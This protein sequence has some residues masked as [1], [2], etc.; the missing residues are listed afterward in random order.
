LS[1]PVEEDGFDV[2]FEDSNPGK[3]HHDD[4]IETSQR[5]EKADLHSD[6]DSGANSDDDDDDDDDG[7]DDDD[8]DEGEDSEDGINELID[9]RAHILHIQMSLYP[10]TLH[11]FLSS[12]DPT[13]ASEPSNNFTH[14]YHLVPTMQIMASILAGLQHVHSAG[15]VHRDIKPQNIFFSFP[16][17]VAESCCD[18][19]KWLNPRIG[20][21]GLVAKLARDGMQLEDWDASQE[22]IPTFHQ[23]GDTTG[24]EQMHTRVGTG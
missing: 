19:G 18:S 8:D 4:D 21:F 5:S 24:E 3:K 23:T 9:P 10:L 17:E 15:M 13:E 22:V 14:C 11:K 12:P 2:F 16:T 1:K 6:P 20:D 7:D